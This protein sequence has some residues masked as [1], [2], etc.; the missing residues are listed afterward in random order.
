MLNEIYD[1]YLELLLEA[2]FN[3]HLLRKMGY[4]FIGRNK[5]LGSETFIHDNDD[6]DPEYHSKMIKRINKNLNKGS[7]YRSKKR[8]TLKDPPAVG[9]SL[10]KHLRG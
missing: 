10:P 7:Y 4:R 3:K 5:R 1:L 8:D 9:I 6:N 2:G